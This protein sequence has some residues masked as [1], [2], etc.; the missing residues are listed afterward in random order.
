MNGSNRA[1]P[2]VRLSLFGIDDDTKHLQSDGVPLIY[3]VGQS[4]KLSSSTW[5]EP[6]SGQRPV[7]Q[8][9]PDEISSEE[10]P[11]LAVTLV[12]VAAPVGSTKTNIY[13]DAL[14]LLTLFLCKFLQTLV[15]QASAKDGVWPPG[16]T[17]GW[18]SL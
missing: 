14:F 17:D 10:R 11:T 7:G 16:H 3:E 4:D 18:T 9:R 2:F 13:T 6:A 1:S 15:P 5:D 8:R 12:W